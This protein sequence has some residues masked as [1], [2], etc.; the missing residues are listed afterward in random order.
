MKNRKSIYTILCMVIALFSASPMF[1]IGTPEPDRSWYKSDGTFWLLIIVIAI[2]FYVIYALAEV[3]VWSGKKKL[4]EKKR[5]GGNLGALLI[6]GSLMFLGNTAQAQDAA[7]MQTAKETIWQ[8]PYLP[9][10]MLIAI[11]IAVIAYLSLMLG[12]LTRKEK[13]MSDEPIPGF[14]SQLWEK[15][16][17]KV[18]IEREEEMLLEDHEYDGIQELDN[19]MPPC[20]GIYFVFHDHICHCVSVVLQYWQRAD[21]DR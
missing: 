14:I 4:E 15:W 5:S 2:L 8:S 18:P 16:N 17:Y 3:V 19:S 9:L 1:A 11:E 12:Q 10:Y 20:C 6:L 7:A 13:A 21:T